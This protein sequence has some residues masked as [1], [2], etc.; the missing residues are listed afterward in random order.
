MSRSTEAPN[1]DRRRLLKIAALGIAAAPFASSLLAGEAS[2]AALPMV[3]EKDP[4]AA[5]LG[6]HCDATKN[7]ARKQADATCAN[8]MFYTANPDGKA[9]L[10]QL[11]QGKN[12]CAAGWCTSWSKKA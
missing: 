5:A 9:G 6:Y 10:C 2:A 8:C 3:D 11:F 4:T 1:A 7:P 12:V